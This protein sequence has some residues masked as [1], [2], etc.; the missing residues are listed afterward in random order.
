MSEKKVLEL[1]KA[2]EHKSCKGCWYDAPSGCSRGPEVFCVPLKIW[3]RKPA[4]ET[5]AMTDHEV[6]RNLCFHDPRNPHN[7]PEL[8]QEPRDNCY[9]DNCFHGRDELALEILRLREE[10]GT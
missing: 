4:E 7:D 5:Q 6:L 1:V 8:G 2:Q 9:C 3:V 10:V